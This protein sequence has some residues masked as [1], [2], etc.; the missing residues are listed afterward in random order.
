MCRHVTTRGLGSR[1]YRGF[2]LSQYGALRCTQRHDFQHF[3][4]HPAH[5]YGPSGRR[6]G[7]AAAGGRGG[8][9]GAL[10][11]AARD[12][13]GPQPPPRV[14]NCFC[15]VGLFPHVRHLKFFKHKIFANRPKIYGKLPKCTTLT[16]PPPAASAPSAFRRPRSDLEMTNLSYP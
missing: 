15:N 13:V 6:A 9:G 7:A 12:F 14:T 11:P 4:L 5:I 3:T 10:R 8:A 16:H 2:E 1:I